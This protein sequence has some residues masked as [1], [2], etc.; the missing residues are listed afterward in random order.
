MLDPGHG[1]QDPGCVYGGVNE[2]DINLAVGLI[3][4]DRLT[5]TEYEA[6]M[7]RMDDTYPTL[8]QRV[9]YE[10]KMMPALYIS[11]H[12]NADPT[13]QAD[14]YMVYCSGSVKGASLAH[15]LADALQ[16]LPIRDRGVALGDFEVIKYTRCPAVL[17]EMGFLDND[18]DRAHLCDPLVQH[19]IADAIISGIQVYAQLQKWPGA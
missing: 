19:A 12:C 13:H 11:L 15:C 2:K 4:R 6:L 17:I 3:L 10:H 5:A 7:T 1:K 8:D 14:G 18:G 9:A 16:S